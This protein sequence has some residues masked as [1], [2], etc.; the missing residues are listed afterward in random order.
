MSR[1]KDQPM[2]PGEAYFHALTIASMVLSEIRIAEMPEDMR[3]LD[4]AAAYTE[5]EIA[6]LEACLNRLAREFKVRAKHMAEAQHEYLE[7]YEKLARRN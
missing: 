4:E 5:Q 2:S 7:H 6:S 1:A 3:R